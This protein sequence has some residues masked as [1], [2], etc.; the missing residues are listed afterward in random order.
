MQRSLPIPSLV[1]DLS[2]DWT[3]VVLRGAVIALFG[4]LFLFA[5][6]FSLTAGT[7]ALAGFA[8]VYGILAL[9]SGLRSSSGSKVLLLVE[10]AVGIVLGLLAFARPGSILKWLVYVIAIWAILSGI[11]QILEAIRIRREIDS[12]WLLALSGACS[13]AFG[14]IALLLPGDALRTLTT[15]LGIYCVVFGALF[16]ALGFRLKSAAARLDQVA[17]AVSTR[18]GRV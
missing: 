1:H 15:V 10:G 8:L 5:P 9:V 17:E 7:Y 2:R 3:T 4:L 14:V 12:E 11:T 13:I 16:V 18:S 6:V